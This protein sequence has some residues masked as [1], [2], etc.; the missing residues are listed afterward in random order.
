MYKIIDWEQD[1]ADK[2][3]VRVEIAGNTV[4][5]KYLAWP[6]DEVVQADAARYDAMM[7]EQAAVHD[8]IM[9]EQADAAPVPE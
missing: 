3:R 1:L 4:M 9:Q 5:F 6:D 8:A 7:Q 2:W